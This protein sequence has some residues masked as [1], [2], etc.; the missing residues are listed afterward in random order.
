MV[1]L[2]QYQL[3]VQAVYALAQR[4]NPAP[5]CRQ[6]LVDV[7][8]EA[9]NKDRIDLLRKAP[10]L[11]SET[12]EFYQDLGRRHLS[13]ARRYTTQRAMALQQSPKR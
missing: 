12:R 6:P 2:E 10:S 1:R 13:A 5:H 4:M 11:G 8:V 7:E 9:L 3:M